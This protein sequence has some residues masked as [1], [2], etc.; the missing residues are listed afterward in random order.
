MN[1]QFNKRPV[2]S[3]L[4]SA[5]TE[6]LNS[7]TGLT[8]SAGTV[9]AV[10]GAV[11]VSGGAVTDIAIT[12][13]GSGYQSLPIITISG[14][15][16]GATATPVLTA[17]VV[18]GITITAGGSGYTAA[19][20]TISA[21][22]R[23]GADIPLNSPNNGAVNLQVNQLG[24]FAHQGLGSRGNNVT[25]STSDTIAH[26]PIIYIAQ[27][28]A[29]S[30]NPANSVNLYP[31]FSRPFE[32]TGDIDGRNGNILVTKR[33]YQAGQHSIWVIGK[34][35][36]HVNAISAED[37]TEY[38]LTITFQGRRE[39]ELYTNHAL[40][41]FSTGFI[42]PNYTALGTA[43]PVDH[44]IQNLTW[45]INRNS[46][47]LGVSRPNYRGN[48]PVIAFAIDS[49]ASA[50]TVISGLTAGTFLPVITTSAG[51]RGITLT[52]EM[53]ANIQT[54]ASA[55]GF[56]TS[57]TIL[58]INL[59][60]AGTT[61]GGV[62]DG[63]MLMA[64]DA[65]LAYRDELTS[66]KTTLNVGL[67]TGF[68][69]STVYHAQVVYAKEANGSGRVLDLQYQASHGQRKYN[70]DHKKDPIVEFPSP[71]SVTTNYDVYQILSVRNMNSGVANLI[72]APLLSTILFP[73][74]A[75]AETSF[76]TLMNAWLTSTGSGVIKTL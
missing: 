29:D 26:A 35:T 32:R 66:R 7:A 15:G 13:G 63:I 70:L 12:S 33:A 44:L 31:L 10:L 46:E 30:A 72:D 47:A 37:L 71:V 9:A 38:G 64:L 20:A 25:L 68:D 54:A 1:S 65:P 51:V 59:A 45:Q 55:A 5:D 43:K 39:E 36:G 42:T 8:A 57:D 56:A 69:F 75:A 67:S 76:E 28:T 17:G 4:V 62:A 14:D 34:P 52:S 74:G 19:T 48:A 21:S 58:N 60:T 22:G 73:A 18:T 16:T 2:Q 23:G 6:I 49:S 61:T 27:G 53:A 3:F 40:A 11:T 41:K 24:V 50:G